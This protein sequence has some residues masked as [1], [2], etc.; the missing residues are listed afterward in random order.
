[1][2]IHENSLR[3]TPPEPTYI[4]FS[5]HE[6]D[7]PTEILKVAKGAIFWRGREICKDEELVSAFRDLVLGH[8]TS[9][10]KSAESEHNNG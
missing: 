5:V 1:M 6:G 2:L 4:S 7:M 3:I 8:K 10:V 9:A